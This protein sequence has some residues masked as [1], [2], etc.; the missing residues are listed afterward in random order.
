MGGACSTPKDAVT[1]ATASP[2]PL[3]SPQVPVEETRPLR[4]AAAEVDGSDVE[5]GF[6]GVELKARQQQ[7]EAGVGVVRR[8]A[9]P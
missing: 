5:T 7:Q 6:H 3:S 1:P 4:S 8:F 2:Q 9:E